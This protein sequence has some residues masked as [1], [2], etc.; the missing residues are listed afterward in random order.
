MRNDSARA[1]AD[2][3]PSGRRC[4][5][6]GYT[7]SRFPPDRIT[8]RFEPFAAPSIAPGW[9]GRMLRMEEVIARDGRIHETKDQYFILADGTATSWLVHRLRLPAPGLRK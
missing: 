8:L 4:G 6:I 5:K 3:L 1:V 2:R 9:A 7:W